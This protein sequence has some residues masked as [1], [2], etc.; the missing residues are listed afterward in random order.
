MASVQKLFHWRK[1]YQ[2]GGLSAV[3]AGEQV[4]A[5]SELADA[6]KQIRE[7]QRMLDNHTPEEK[8]YNLSSRQKT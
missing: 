5:A 6:I 7:R 8:D 1:P 3:E 2:D 4:V